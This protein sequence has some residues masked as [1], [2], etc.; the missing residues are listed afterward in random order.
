MKKAR[1][2]DPLSLPIS[3]D[4]GFSLYYSGNYDAAITSLQES[5]AKDPGFPAAHLWLGRAYEEKSMYP[6]A[7]AEFEKVLKELPGWPVAIAAT[8]WVYGRWGKTAEARRVL[9]ELNAQSKRRYVSSYAIALVHA[10]LGEKNEA[11]HFLDL[12]L[13]ERTNWM[14][15]TAVD[16][17]WQPIRSDPRFKQLVHEI[18]L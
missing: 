3:T 18:G 7:I 17:R 13:K 1:E 4:E 8:G 15:W 12:G 16:P 6:E 14:V 9:A 2:L 10:G 5:L 11:L